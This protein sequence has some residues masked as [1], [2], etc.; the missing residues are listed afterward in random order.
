MW[1][2]PTTEWSSKIE[3]D[4]K[5]F[6]NSTEIKDDA[7]SYKFNMELCALVLAVIIVGRILVLSTGYLLYFYNKGPEM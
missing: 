6:K 2:T 3:I 7:K 1:Q 4:G 5:T